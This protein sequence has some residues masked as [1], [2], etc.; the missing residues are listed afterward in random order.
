MRAACSRALSRYYAEG[1]TPR[2]GLLLG[3]A[4]VPENDI[5]RKFELVLDSLAEVAQRSRA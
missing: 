4:C 3:Y 5:A 1:T 2:Q